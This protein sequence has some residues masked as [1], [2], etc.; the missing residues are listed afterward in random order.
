MA[1]TPT[2]MTE[3]EAAICAQALWLNN[4]GDYEAVGRA[5][6]VSPERAAELCAICS[7][8]Q[9]RLDVGAMRMPQEE[10]ET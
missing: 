1:K 3:L 8:A 9:A 6:G 2:T 7:D 5:L 4:G 10:R